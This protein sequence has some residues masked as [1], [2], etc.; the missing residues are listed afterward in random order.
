MKKTLL[1]LSFLVFLAIIAAAIPAS[2]NLLANGSFET[3]VVDPTS[4]CGPFAN[5]HGFHSENGYPVSDS[6]IGGW[7]V[8]GRSDVTCVGSVCTPNGAPAPVML[9]TN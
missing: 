7:S 2:A 3:P 5:C 4:Q 6:N 1:T 8:I 9:M